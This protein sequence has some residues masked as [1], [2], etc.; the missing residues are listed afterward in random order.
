MHTNKN[1]FVLITNYNKTI[2]VNN[3]YFTINTYVN[4]RLKFGNHNKCLF[5]IFDW[6]DSTSQTDDLQIRQIYV[7]TSDETLIMNSPHS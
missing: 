7:K 3:L 1:T 6:S 2:E 5:R 4:P